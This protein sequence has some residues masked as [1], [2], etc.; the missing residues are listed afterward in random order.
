M[1]AA[2]PARLAA[3]PLTSEASIPMPTTYTT[4]DKLAAGVGC[5]TLLLLAA[6]G[7]GTPAATPPVVPPVVA[8][9][10][11]L[12]APVSQTLAGGKAI[13][14]AATTA[15]GAAASWQ[16]A[17]GSPGSLSA[18]SGASVNYVP[19]ASVAANTQVNIV[20]SVGGISKTLTLTVFPDPGSP[21]LS[22]LAGASAGSSPQP[23]DGQ[24][25]AARFENPH[26]MGAA[27][28]GAIYVAD[29]VLSGVLTEDRFSLRKI[30]P[31]GVVTTLASKIDLSP[32]YYNDVVRIAADRSGAVYLLENGNYS[33]GNNNPAG[34]A[35]YKLGAD[36]TPVLFAGVA[37][38]NA[39]SGEALQQDGN[40]AAAHFY[41]PNLVGFDAENNLYLKDSP[42]NVTLNRPYRKVTPQ[43]VV[44]TIDALPAGVGGAADG[45][46][47]T[48]SA[49]TSD[50][51]V[52]RGKAGGTNTAVAGV[53]GAAGDLLGPLPGQ[54]SAPYG[55]VPLGP[56]SFAF[57]SNQ[58]VIKLV[59]P[60]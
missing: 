19:P 59:V 32:N 44:T 42:R 25:A 54:L 43:G 9:S 29:F 37:S 8:E 12:N 52:I 27:P 21:L 15:S 28:D 55:L 58:R 17:A 10:L 50:N 56:Y 6:C 51:V 23:A 5:A 60:R 7:G 31:A 40:G 53:W 26:V 45:N 18:A 11:S 34:G 35:I 22:L 36:G 20:A 39:A 48:Y 47:D 38:H 3:I 16:L 2:S 14:L 41:Q 13:G 33:I 4:I 24:G 57:L 46:P 49:S 30:S 1:C